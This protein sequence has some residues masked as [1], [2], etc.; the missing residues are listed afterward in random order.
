M[1]FAGIGLAGMG[2]E[3]A[4]ADVV[5]VNDLEAFEHQMYAGQLGTDRHDYVVGDV[6]TSKVR[7]CLT[8]T[9]RGR[10]SRAQTSRSRGTAP[11]LPAR[12]NQPSLHS[13]AS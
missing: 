7:A 10:P 5:W 3:S 11:A 2:L 9:W 4:G 12:P 8:S 13:P 6:G 1:L